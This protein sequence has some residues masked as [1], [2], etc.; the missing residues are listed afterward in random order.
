MEGSWSVCSLIIQDFVNAKNFT[1]WW[2]A[3]RYASNQSIDDS[4][5]GIWDNKS[6][7][8]EVIVYGGD[9]YEN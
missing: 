7:E 4:I 1:D 2:E 6:G 3:Q 9:V 5:Y 8:L